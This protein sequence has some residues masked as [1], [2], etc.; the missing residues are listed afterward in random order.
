MHGVATRV[1]ATQGPHLGKY[2]QQLRD[3]TSSLDGNAYCNFLLFQ[4]WQK[5]NKTILLLASMD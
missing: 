5:Y 2:I 1:T 3:E 4:L